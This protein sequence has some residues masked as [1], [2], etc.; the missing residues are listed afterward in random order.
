[1]SWALDQGRRVWSLYVRS[2]L[3]SIPSDAL[4]ECDWWVDGSPVAWTQSNE[5]PIL[6]A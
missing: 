3:L 5:T 6:N 1:M 2:S 4:L